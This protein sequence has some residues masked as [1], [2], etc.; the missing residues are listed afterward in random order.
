MFGIEIAYIK[1]VNLKHT[2]NM[3]RITKT[4]NLNGVEIVA[5]CN[6]SNGTDCY[7][8]GNWRKRF[9]ITFYINKVGKT[10][11]FHDSASRYPKSADVNTLE[12]CLEC[13]LNDAIAYGN[14]ISL[15]DFMSEFGYENRMEGANAY[16]G[17]KKAYDFFEDREIDIY[18]TLNQFDEAL[19]I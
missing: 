6:Q 11:Y 5:V 2:N 13:V 10:F 14:S 1:S 17:C 16:N 15:D 18:E 8:W 9:A 7:K 3:S 4:F 19:G 12:N